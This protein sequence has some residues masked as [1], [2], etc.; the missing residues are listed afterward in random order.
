MNTL[1]LYFYVEEPSIKPVINRIIGEIKADIYFQIFVHQGKQDLDNSLKKTIPSVSSIPN[2][3]I[4]ILRDQDSDDCKVLKNRILGEVTLRCRCPFK[5][6]IVCNELEAWFL[7]DMD[8]IKSAYP[9]FIPKKYKNKSRFRII[10]SIVSP[11]KLLFN[12]VPELK[13]GKIVSKRKTSQEISK[14]LDIA[15]N[16]SDSFNQ[17]VNAIG[18]LIDVKTNLLEQ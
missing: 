15:N 11:S 8:A 2:S 9:R 13:I 4:I 6:R 1:T 14:H 7:G 16:K 3:R 5:I 12:I 18:E 17:F 10:D